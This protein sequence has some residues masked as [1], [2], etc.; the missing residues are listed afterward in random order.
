MK[1]R[2]RSL[3]QQWSALIPALLFGIIVEASV[4]QYEDEYPSETR[5]DGEVI[6][7]ATSDEAVDRLITSLRSEFPGES[8]RL[9][10]NNT[11]LA[12][13]TISIPIPQTDADSSLLRQ[14]ID[15]SVNSG[16]MLWAEPT[17]IVDVDGLG[18]QT[19]SL[20]VS[21]LDINENSYRNQYLRELMRIDDAQNSATGRGVLVAIV[22]TGIDGTHPA[23]GNRVSPH[24]VSLIE[25]YP[26]A[27]DSASGNPV[28]NNAMRGHGTFIAGL[29]RLIAPDAG[30][31]PIRVLDSEGQGTTTRAADGITVA[32][33]KG[34]HVIV[35]AFGTPVQSQALN[36]AIQSARDAGVIVL[37][38]AGNDGEPQ[39]HYP[40]SNPSCFTLGASDHRDDAF[41]SS[42]H[43][44]NIDASAPGS[45]LAQGT[46]ADPFGSIIGPFPGIGS[47]A[48]YRAS[49]G[50]SFATACAAGVAALIRSQH[51]EWPSES[52]PLADIPDEI[53]RRLRQS[54][55]MTRFPDP[56]GARPRI[57]ALSA[58]GSDDQA[59]EV[60][61]I[62]GD[63][64][65][66]AMDLGALL[67]GF[68]SVPAGQFL[69]LADVDGNF[70][71]G[72]SDIGLLLASWNP[73][74]AGIPNGR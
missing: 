5:V 71:I 30:L 29:V 56:A 8:I 72:T 23:M 2:V 74:P 1:T 11:E 38:A 9:L 46:S 40:A 27:D 14:I 15:D 60:G 31:L 73:C 59:P 17:M 12:L 35:L 43:C 25:G 50:T 4:A 37:A 54:S 19:G 33:S 64:C 70:E 39:C 21:G 67:G 63:G 10:S 45:I 24:G 49:G 13:Y 47:N 41:S 55:A 52:L 34:A 16:D 58:T 68:G 48:E 42:N 44:A 6:L 62:N 7:Q 20:W 57:D 3:F 28:A 61:D 36:A 53:G 65:V 66:D 69:H 18:G 51:P 22:D 32:V 26:Y